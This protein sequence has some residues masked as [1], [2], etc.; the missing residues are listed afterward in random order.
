MGSD[1][2][3]IQTTNSKSKVLFTGEAG[4]SKSTAISRVLGL[5]RSSDKRVK[6]TPSNEYSVT[7]IH[8]VDPS[9]TQ[10]NLLGSEARSP[11]L[12]LNRTNQNKSVKKNFISLNKNHVG[13]SL[14]EVAK[15]I[16][17]PVQ[18]NSVT[19]Q[20]TAQ[21]SHYITSVEDHLIRGKRSPSVLKKLNPP[22]IAT[23]NSPKLAP[24][25]LQSRS[26]WTRKNPCY[27]P[28][29]REDSQIRL[30]GVSPRPNQ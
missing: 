20:N 25:S 21:P 8:T 4:G 24:T 5:I 11:K 13:G 18:T 2:A 30:K 29:K 28:Q 9:K 7:T 14:L 12:T 27:F 22:Q 26:L 19:L 3:G 15:I 6:Y 17:T 1:T 23:P 16:R 10:D